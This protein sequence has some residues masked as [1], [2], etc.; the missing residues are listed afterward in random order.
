MNL[1]R[2]FSSGKLYKVSR[3][4]IITANNKRNNL[5]KSF[6]SNTSIVENKNA[7]FTSYKVIDEVEEEKDVPWIREEDC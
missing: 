4:G 6:K 5:N 2:D 1:N 3:L 7:L